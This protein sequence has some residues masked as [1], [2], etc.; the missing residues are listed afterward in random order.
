MILNLNNYFK[1][2]NLINIDEKDMI[3]NFFEKFQ[4]IAEN[5]KEIVHNRSI[6]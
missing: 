5:Y 6:N 3:V 4:K 1:E 2:N